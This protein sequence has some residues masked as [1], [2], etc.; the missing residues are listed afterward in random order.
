MTN[1]EKYHEEMIKNGYTAVKNGKPVSCEIL[2]QECDIYDEDCR[3]ALVKWLAKEYE[4]PKPTL[5]KRQRALC[6]AL[7]CGYLARDSNNSLWYYSTKPEKNIEQNKW[8]GFHG[9]C[10]WLDS[11]VFPD[12]PFIKWEDEEPHSIEDMLTWEVE[13]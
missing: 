11:Q 3:I 13:K 7:G 10:T 8:F 12:F 5:T 1:F 6:E 9:V 2:C 4:E